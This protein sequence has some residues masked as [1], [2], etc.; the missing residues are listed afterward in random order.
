MIMLWRFVPI[1]MRD[2]QF[3]VREVA[4]E[5]RGGA[6][7]LSLSRAQLVTR[8]LVVAVASGVAG[9]ALVAL[10][11]ALKELRAEPETGFRYLFH[12]RDLFSPTTLFDSIQL[13]SLL[14]FMTVCGL[15]GAAVAAA[16]R[17]AGRDLE[18]G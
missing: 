6:P 15:L 2:P 18:T 3:V 8:G 7:A 9:A 12:V 17:G 11:A 5:T 10:L 16:R 14:A 13:F 4:A 1:G